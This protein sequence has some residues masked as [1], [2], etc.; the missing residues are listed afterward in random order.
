MYLLY[1]DESGTSA[2]PGNTSHF[3]L[4]GVSIPIWHWK[5]CDREIERVKQRYSLCNAEIHTAWILR[6]YLEQTRIPG[7]EAL[8]YTQRR[9]EVERFRRAELLRLQRSGNK[10]HYRQTKKN[11]DKTANYI[12]LTHNE[13]TKFGGQRT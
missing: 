10:K 4:T 12:H 5:N 7:F 6:R 1:I 3:I 11:F 8:S 9:S 13:R 2:I